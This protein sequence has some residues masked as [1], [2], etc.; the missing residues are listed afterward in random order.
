MYLGLRLK[1]TIAQIQIGRP[2]FVLEF[3]ALCISSKYCKNG[4]LNPVGKVKLLLEERGHPLDLSHLVNA[5]NRNYRVE[6]L[7]QP[8]SVSEAKS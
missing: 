8:V 4:S 2:A 7:S 3:Y 5:M 6:I 1:K